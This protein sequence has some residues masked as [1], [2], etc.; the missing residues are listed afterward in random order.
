MPSN[1]DFD[2]YLHYLVKYQYAE[3]DK[4]LALLTKFLKGEA[5]IGG[6]ICP[7]YY[8]FFAFFANSRILFGGDAPG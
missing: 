2:E 3:Y 5:E 4:A 6:R 8:N 1:Q 7:Y